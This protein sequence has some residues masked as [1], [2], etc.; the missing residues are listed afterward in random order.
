MT[1]PAP[2][3]KADRPA[4]AIAIL[5]QQG[6][7]LMQL[8]DNIPGIV[9]PGHWAFFGGHIEPGETPEVA[10]KRELLEEIGYTPPVLSEFGLYADSKVV[11]H[12]YSGT[13]TVPVTDLVLG[14]GWDLGLLTLEDI[15]RGDRYSEQA[16]QVRPLG[17][18]HQ[19]IL[20]D[21]IDQHP[22]AL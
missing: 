15:Q 4:V 10:V 18:P 6:Q 16:N 21:F 8:R 3:A 14:E 17:Q 19:K 1:Q 5:H 20:L 9:Y 2:V 22:D 11:R 12:V 7:F 13:L